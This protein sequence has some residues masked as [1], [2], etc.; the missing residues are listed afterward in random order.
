MFQYMGKILLSGLQGLILGEGISPSMPP[1]TRNVGF[2]PVRSSLGTV[3]EPIARLNPKPYSLEGEMEP[4]THGC[5]IKC[6][7]EARSQGFFWGYALLFRVFPMA[8]PLQ[9]ALEPLNNPYLN[10]SQK[11]QALILK[12]TLI[13]LYP[14]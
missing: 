8:P 11:P 9:S 2:I 3:M 7:S 13:L 14:L 1:Q 10:P 12:P 6:L 5:S 4:I